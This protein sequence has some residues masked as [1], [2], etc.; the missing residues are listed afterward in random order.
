MMLEYFPVDTC[1]TVLIYVTLLI[2]AVI[3]LLL[4]PPRK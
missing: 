3:V 1:D 4:K 2:V